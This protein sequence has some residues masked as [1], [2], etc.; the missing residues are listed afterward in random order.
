[1]CYKKIDAMML[2]VWI[3]SLRQ[4]PV[5]RSPQIVQ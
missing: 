3:E 2:T 4:A 5:G 1:M